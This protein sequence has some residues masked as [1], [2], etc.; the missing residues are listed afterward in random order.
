[1]KL[2]EREPNVAVGLMTGAETV[3]LELK[4][5]FA[6]GGV[7]F[8]AGKYQ[9][10]TA[11]NRIELIDADGRR[12]SAGEELKLSPVDERSSFVVR[13]VVIGID[14]H[15]EQKQD[16]QFQGALRLKLGADQR[17]TVINDVPVEAYLTSV[18]SSEMSATADAELLKAHAVI[19]RSWLLAQLPDWKRPR[20]KSEPKIE[21]VNGE[22]QLIR[23]Y[24]QEAHTEF[25]VCA[26]DH[27]QRY[28]GIS[29]ATSPMVFDVI[30]QTFGQVLTFDDE[31]CD[32][33][34]S[35]SCG[36][37]TE[38]FDAAWAD[39]KFPYLAVAYD[40]ENFPENFALPLTEEA[41]AERWIRQSPPAF[42]NT[43][44]PKVLSKILPDFDRA[45]RDFYRWR[46][47]LRQGELQELLR[48]KLGVE[49][50]AIHKLE[51]VER[52]AS[53][54]LVKLRI[55]GE[56]EQLIIGKELEIRRALSPSHL[57][58][59]AFVVETSGHGSN[60]PEQ[61]ILIGA[62]WGH[63]VGLCQ[64]GA[65]LMAERGYGCE[66]ILA[67]YYQGSRLQALYQ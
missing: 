36:G 51:P 35:K 28:Q 18:I 65:A 20:V 49:F 61:F 23:W 26:D 33:R 67:H 3:N 48:L 13:D 37:M 43:T 12:F 52:A 50:G 17:L 56:R 47:T 54:R 39:E 14:F 46:V 15:W 4:G 63:G 9:A 64:I 25:D 29:K 24:D 31:L 59:S 30:A 22:R 45:T 5:E 42:C 7:R 58:S 66:Q 10:V 16:Q 57:Y 38:S 62:G 41:N 27:C 32:A 34:F 60:A 6:A 8:A 55:V 53:G 2:I 11:C 1:M 21:T 44:E 40:G 19:S